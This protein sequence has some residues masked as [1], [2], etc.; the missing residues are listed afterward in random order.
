[1]LAAQSS[2]PEGQPLEPTRVVEVLRTAVVSF[3]D[4]IT[5]RFL[6]LFPGGPEALSK[7]S[8]DEIRAISVVD[9]RPHPAIPPCVAGS[10]VLVAL[11]DPSRQLYVVSLGDS[12][13]GMS[14]LS[15]QYTTLW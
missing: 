12:I 8:D 3:D 2:A 13:A 5:Q 4:E 11:L 9:G 15:S 7:L 1:M 14:L 6:D 10:T